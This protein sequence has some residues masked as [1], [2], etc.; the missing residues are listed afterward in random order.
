MGNCSGK[1][2]KPSQAHQASHAHQPPHTPPEPHAQP[3][4]PHA[5]PPD[6]TL[7][8]VASMEIPIETTVAYGTA[9]DTTPDS[10]PL[11]PTAVA[12]KLP[13]RDLHPGPTPVPAP[14]P[15]AA[16]IVEVPRPTRPPVKA[17]PINIQMPLDEAILQQHNA[18]RD[19]H[20]APPLELDDD[21]CDSAQAHADDLAASGTVSRSLTGHGENIY[22][23]CSCHQYSKEVL[24]AVTTWYAQ[25]DGF[26]YGLP[27]DPTQSV[28]FT[29]MLWAATKRLG[30]GIATRNRENALFETYVVC[31]YE[32]KGNTPG[33]FHINIGRERFDEL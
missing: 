29:Q 5:Q 10:A 9:G 26:H 22:Y 11:T 6:P 19:D 20:G 24:E 33:M 14:A 28:E 3:P 17:P 4:E 16:K 12:P 18:F 31:H 13:Q 1:E 27:D 30:I 23:G 21:L 7:H 15:T 25:G 32:P 2:V 8:R